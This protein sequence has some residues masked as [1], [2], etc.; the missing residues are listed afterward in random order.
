MLS[1]WTRETLRPA[2]FQCFQV[3]AEGSDTGKVID[4]S[5]DKNSSVFV[6]CLSEYKLVCF[7]FLFCFGFCS[8][9]LRRTN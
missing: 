5:C 8:F 9:A 4:F 1:P 7:S 3:N 2:G 6:Q